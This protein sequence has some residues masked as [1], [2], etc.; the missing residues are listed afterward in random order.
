[1]AGIINENSIN[2]AASKWRNI[3]I[4]EAAKAKEKRQQ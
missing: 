4:N 2:I 3:S 1:M